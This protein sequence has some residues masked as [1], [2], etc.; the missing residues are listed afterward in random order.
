MVIKLKY[1]PDLMYWN[2][3]IVSNNTLYSM[4]SK[5]YLNHAS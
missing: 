2:V 3:H 1:K 5:P 4:K